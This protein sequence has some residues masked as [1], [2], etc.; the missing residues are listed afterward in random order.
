MRQDAFLNISFELLLIKAHPS[1]FTVLIYLATSRAAR[2]GIF[3]HFRFVNI[4]HCRQSINSLLYVYYTDPQLFFFFVTTLLCTTDTQKNISV[5][6]LVYN[7][8]TCSNYTITP[9][10]S[11]L[12]NFFEKVNKG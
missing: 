11:R 8:A 12:S 2:L 4:P 10:M 1:Y 5:L 7:L 9:I 6:S 3:T